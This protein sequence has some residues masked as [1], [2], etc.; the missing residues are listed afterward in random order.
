MPSKKKNPSLGRRIRKYLDKEY[1]SITRRKRALPDFI[2]AG[3]QKAGTSS[4]FS[5]LSQHPALLPSSTKEV[6][7]FDGGLQTDQD[8][9]AHGSDW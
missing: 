3:A 7:F 1:R 6:H 9:Y 8:V 4:L 2:I 5:C